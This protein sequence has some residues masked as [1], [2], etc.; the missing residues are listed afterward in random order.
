MQVAGNKANA[1]I[2]QW[3]LALGYLRPACHEELHTII[4]TLAA[5]K[6]FVAPLMSQH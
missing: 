2:M 1:W 5:Y 4:I 6:T 3:A